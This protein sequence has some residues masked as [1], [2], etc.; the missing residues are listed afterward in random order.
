MPLS[1]AVRQATSQRNYPSLLP[2]RRP[3][4]PNLR[5]RSLFLRKGNDHVVR[6]HIASFFF[7]LDLTSLSLVLTAGLFIA[8]KIDL[9]HIS[10]V[11]SYALFFFYIC[12][13]VSVSRGFYLPSN[14]VCLMLTGTHTICI[15]YRLLP[16][17]PPSHCFFLHSIPLLM[18]CLLRVKYM[19]L[20]SNVSFIAKIWASR[21]V[22]QLPDL[23]PTCTDYL[24]Y[25]IDRDSRILRTQG[26]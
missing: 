25:F 16:T 20:P 6:I 24:S 17:L 8:I 10:T 4:P 13:L 21:P 5:R 22:L 12:P 7:R 18:F 23:Y 3:E 15:Y 2:L 14:L 11:I 26:V 19:L 9:L 1:L